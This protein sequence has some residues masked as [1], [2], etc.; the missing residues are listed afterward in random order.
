MEREILGEIMPNGLKKEDS[1]ALK[2]IAVLMLVFHHCYRIAEKFEKYEVVFRGFSAEQVITIARFGKICVAIFAFV[3][4]YG[5]MCGYISKV[6]EKSPRSIWGYSSRHLLST[7]SGFWFTAIVFYLL[8]FL[9]DG[10]FQKWGDTLSERILAV[11]LDIFGTARLLGT[12][13]LNGSWWY[14][15]AAL[16]FILLLPFLAACIES[17]GGTICMILLFLL[18]R[19]L[20]IGFPGGTSYWSFLMIFAAG[21]ICCKY[22]F[23]ARFHEWSSK[24]R[25]FCLTLS[26]LVI[27]VFLYYQID[28]KT[29]WEFQYAWTPFI[30][31]VFCV[32]YLFRIKP[33]TVFLQYLGKHS[34]NIWLV[35]TFVRDWCG[36]YVFGVREFWLIPIVILGVSLLISYCLD[37]LKKLTGY[38]RL[39]RYVQKKLADLS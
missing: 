16:V 12:K 24:S 11:T 20:Q 37:F 17:Y 4:G 7:A 13:S 5:L 30:V 10:S 38:D 8:Y 27:T 15:S 18:P 3:S 9:R 26:V 35:H 19:M 29:L 33:L 1:A 21:M 28:L 2:G 39:I 25:K 34:M 23:F 22:D 14:M 36:P 31:I 6:K 32:E